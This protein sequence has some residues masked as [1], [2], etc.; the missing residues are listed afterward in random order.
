MIK[1]ETIVNGTLEQ[2]WEK[3]TEPKHITQWYFAS[4]EWHA[5]AAEN[6]LRVGGKFNTRME[7]KDGS[8]GFDYTGEYT[9][10]KP[11]ERFEYKLG[12]L[13]NGIVEFKKD[14]NQIVVTEHFDPETENP[15]DMQQTGWQM[16]LNNFKAYAEK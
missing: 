8:F 2:V 11:F 5:P 12:D 9:V 16:I 15:H 10:V 14:G 6:D 1:V 4:P 3:F 7:A 13:R